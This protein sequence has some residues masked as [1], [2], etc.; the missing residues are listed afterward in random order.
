MP[1]QTVSKTFSEGRWRSPP[2]RGGANRQRS[3]QTPGCQKRREYTRTH[4]TAAQIVNFPGYE[5]PVR[6]IRVLSPFCRLLSACSDLGGE[7]VVVFKD[8]DDLLRRASAL[9]RPRR[10]DVELGGAHHFVKP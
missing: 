3:N 1:P 9:Y 10:L 8:P 7:D 5:R 2:L 4:E 6:E